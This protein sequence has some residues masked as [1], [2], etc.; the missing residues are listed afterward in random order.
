MMSDFCIVFTFALFNFSVL[1][2][3]IFFISVV[4]WFMMRKSSR[5]N[6]QAKNNYLEFKKKNMNQK[7]ISVELYNLH[8]MQVHYSVSSQTIC[9]KNFNLLKDNQLTFWVKL[10]FCK[11][12]YG[13][14]TC[15]YHTI[16]Y[17]YLL[18]MYIH[19][20]IVKNSNRQRTNDSKLNEK[21]Q[22]LS[23][24]ILFSTELIG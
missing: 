12:A 10:E 15:T 3:F 1:N 21:P 2:K 9:F 24:L 13:S 5:R 14:Y 23:L 8:S 17:I 22:R 19:I 20:C 18:L 4:S 11:G 6:Q 16:I 7:F